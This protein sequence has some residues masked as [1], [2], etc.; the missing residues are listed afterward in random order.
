MDPYIIT[1]EAIHDMANV[2]SPG[3]LLDIQRAEDYVEY[4]AQWKFN[5][6]RNICMGFMFGFGFALLIIGIMMEVF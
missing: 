3:R 4:R 6:S 2:F 5:R 1:D